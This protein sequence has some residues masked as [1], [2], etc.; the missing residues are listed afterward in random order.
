MFNKRG[1]LTIFII[2][3]IVLLFSVSVYF[4]IVTRE[5]EA[6]LDSQRSGPAG[7][8]YKYV[9]ECIENASFSALESFGFQQGY[10]RVP[11]EK[12]IETIFYRI[13]YY[14]LKGEILIPSN[15]FFERELG[16]ILDDRISEDCSD[17]LDFEGKFEIN[18][19]DV[20]SK[21]TIL[22]DSIIININYPISIRSGETTIEISKFAY[23]L[24]I[25]L[26]HIIDVSRILVEKIREE[27]DAIDLTFLLKQDIDISI[28][29]YDKC[30]KI[31]I[32]L[33]EMSETNT[34]DSYIF[35]F[36]VGFKEEYCTL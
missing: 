9:E 36:A 33:D 20:K 7:E 34:D 31:Y 18:P 15:D 5:S 24:Q 6:S 2:V 25:R 35:S 32:L 1:Q 13:A 19:R 4:F 11:E 22:E 23:T 10:H 14:Y 28:D 29:N 8:V 27:P 17:F 26:G 3:A 21:A 30:N 16:K 12:S